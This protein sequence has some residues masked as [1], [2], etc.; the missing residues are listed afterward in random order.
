MSA[1]AMN[2]LACHVDGVGGSGMGQTLDPAPVDLLIFHPSTNDEAKR[3]W[4]DGRR[5]PD[6]RTRVREQRQQPWLLLLCW[7]LVGSW[8]AR[9]CLWM[10]G[11]V[12]GE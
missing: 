4:M 12:D 3:R 11:C 9:R 5:E 1:G 6:A 10:L 7:E 2:L 8:K